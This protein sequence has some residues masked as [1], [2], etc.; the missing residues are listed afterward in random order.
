MLN[1]FILV[2]TVMETPQL[3]TTTTGLKYMNLMIDSQRSF[4]NVDGEYEHDVI[5]CKLW[6]TIAENSLSYCQEG[7]V[8]GV[9]GRIQS[10]SHTSDEGVTYYNY[11]LIV[12]KI[13]HILNKQDHL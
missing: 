11:E 6:R 4:K 2:G 7:N 5:V 3:Q 1:Q 13:S 12:E 9:K 8:V 10:Y